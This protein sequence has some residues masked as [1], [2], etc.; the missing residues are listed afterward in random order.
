MVL[1]TEAIILGIVKYKDKNLIIKAYTKEQ[2]LQSFFTTLSSGKSKNKSKNNYQAFSI[3]EIVY[4]KDNKS[5]LLRIKESRNVH[6]LLEL[7]T[8]IHKNA[9]AFLLAEVF[10]KCI[11]EEEEN[12]QLYSFIEQQII[13]LNDCNTAYSNFH[14]YSLVQFTKQ[15]G[16]QPEYKNHFKYFDIKEGAFVASIPFHSHFMEQ[17]SAELLQQLLILP[18]ED[19]KKITLNGNKRTEFL[20][21]LL[22][23]YQY[24]VPGFQTPL[25]LEVL[26]DVFHA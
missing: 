20:T 5:N 8:N 15:L 2:G 6:L 7:R 3:L 17:E 12:P 4:R 24:H 16:I 9:I 13:A 21:E 1:K 22:K 10:G 23:Y 19:A 26:S 14:I 11:L 25:S 18:W